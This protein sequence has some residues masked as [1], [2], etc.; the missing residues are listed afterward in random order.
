MAEDSPTCRIHER[1]IW[2]KCANP[3]MSMD[4]QG[5]C[6][7]HSEDKSKDPVA[8]REA[9][10]AIWNR[11]DSASHDFRAVFFPDSFAPVDFFGFRDF[12]RPIDF[13]RATFT[14]TASFIGATFMERADFSNVTFLDDVHFFEATFIKKVDF[15]DS[16]FKK[17]ADFIGTVFHEGASFFKARFQ[18]WASFSGS[19]FEGVA[20]FLRAIIEGQVIFRPQQVSKCIFRELELNP[21][22]K[23]L[24]QN[25]SLAQTEF[26]GTHFRLIEFVHVKWPRYKGRNV[27][28]D[29][30]VLKKKPTSEEYAQVEH[31]YR[32]LIAN[33]KNQEDYKRVGD[34]HYGEMEMHR[35]ANPWRRW[36]SWY[37]I[38]WALSGYGE[39]P[40][41][42]LIWLMLF[43]FGLSGL[44]CWLGLPIDDHGNT[45]NLLDSIVYILQK[46]SLQRP[47]W[48]KVNSIGTRFW[49]SLSVLL[50]PGQAALF[51]LALR[52]R[53]GRRR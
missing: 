46:A 34:F 53:L 36:L 27:V 29:E 14:E 52:N 41:R 26:T 17:S 25:V 33:C 19:T 32:Q 3:A 23:L 47:E 1:Y 5:L 44:V 49:S 6:I 39:S 16:I 21:G 20:D 48:P 42:A 11:E 35:K 50:I 13:S 28:Y 51:L 4:P 40:R 45:A 22:G 10:L 37:S 2:I 18:L 8:F 24:F 12:Q 43:F 30:I 9:L 7:L 31:L 38:Y 15:I